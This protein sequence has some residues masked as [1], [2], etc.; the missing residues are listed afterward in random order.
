MSSVKI[1]AGVVVVAAVAVAA[2]STYV[3]GSKAESV[4][5]TELVGAIKPA[6]GIS[7]EVLDYNRSFLSATAKTKWTIRHPDGEG[8]LFDFTFN[9]DIKHG[10][11]GAGASAVRVHSELQTPEVFA[12]DLKSVFGDKSVLTVD[13]NIGWGGG[14]SHHVSSPEYRGKVP[15]SAPKFDLFWGG[16]E[17]D[18]TVDGGGKRARLDITLPGLSSEDPDEGNKVVVGAIKITSDSSKS[19]Q[20]FFWTGSANLSVASIQAS[21]DDKPP[22]SLEQF[23]VSSEVVPKDETLDLVLKF[24]AGKIEAAGQK[25]DGAKAT[26]AYENIDIGAFDAFAQVLDGAASAEELEAKFVPLILEQ[27]PVLLGRKPAVALRDVGVTFPE[28]SFKFD[29]RVAYVGGGQVE[30]FNPGTDLAG[31]LNLSFPR[32]LVTRLL[33]AQV[34]AAVGGRGSDDEDEDEDDEEDG[35][36]NIDEVVNDQV[37][38]QLAMLTGTGLF[39]EKEGVFSSAVIYKEGGFTVNGKAFDP[40]LFSKLLPF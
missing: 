8:P 17:G 27:A 18:I 29:L 38:Q 24:G 13:S 40:S 31:E 23:S 16:I 6:S 21:I 15:E 36:E 1:V 28:G 4:F 33:G 3:A 5:R 2:G 7:V 39:E 26:L 34:R 37:D 19:A 10:L 20:H 35:E 12:E 14:Q 30:A 22:F 32:A 25:I 9:H 11:L